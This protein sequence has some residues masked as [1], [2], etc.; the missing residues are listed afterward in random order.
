M[1]DAQIVAGRV[2]TRTGSWHD[3]L[4]ALVWASFPLAK[5]ALHAKQHALVVANGPSAA[6]RTPE[7]DALAMI[8][9]GG[10]VVAL[11]KG[12]VFGHGI[13]EGLVRDWVP[14]VGKAVIV[15]GADPDAGLAAAIEGGAYMTHVRMSLSDVDTPTP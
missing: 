13:Y 2:P 10:I 4:N 14:P 15:E 5:R 7:L 8:D 6:C 9:E 1:Y 11:G 3:F 12:M